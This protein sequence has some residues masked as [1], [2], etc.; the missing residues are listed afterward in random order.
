MGT[1]NF[2][3]YAKKFDLQVSSLIE[4]YKKAESVASMNNRSTNQLYINGL[5]KKMIG[6]KLSFKEFMVLIEDEGVPTNSVGSVISSHEPTDGNP[7]K[8]KKK[9]KKKSII[10]RDI[11]K[12]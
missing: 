11:I 9:K 10:K 6:E 2:E 4:T 3:K 8:T 12:S 1:V 7:D 5:F